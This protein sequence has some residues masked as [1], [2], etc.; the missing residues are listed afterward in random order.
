[1]KAASRRHAEA[2][3]PLRLGYSPFVNHD[4]IR[5]ALVGYHE[6]VPEGHMNS[7]SDCTAKLMDMLTDGRL[8]AALITLPV[9]TEGLFEHRICEDRLVICLRR[10][11]AFASQSEIPKAAIEE[12]LRIFF[13]RDYHPALYDRLIRRFKRAG[14]DLHPTE[15]YS[16]RAEMQF[17]VKTQGCFGLIKEHIPLD[18]GLITRP[19]AGL[20][21]RI[22][23]ALVCHRDQQRSVFPMLAYRMAQRCAQQER[24]VPRKPPNRVDPEG[25]PAIREDIA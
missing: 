14:I 13:S 19:M 5:E 1:M 20:D 25:T 24:Q 17:L 10:D 4:L 21:L 12:R 2:E 16:A 6:I 22:G 8:D 9:H 7:S 11:D 23:T 15:T 18:P 3:W